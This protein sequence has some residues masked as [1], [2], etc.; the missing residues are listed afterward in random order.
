MILVLPI[1][2]SQIIW[3]TSPNSGLLGRMN[4][5]RDEHGMLFEEAVEDQVLFRS[6]WVQ[7]GT[8]DTKMTPQP[9]VILGYIYNIIYSFDSL[10]LSESSARQLHN[11]II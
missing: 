9:S 6:G 7:F 8:H 4:P 3:T 2:T 11:N 10:K 1:S 5:I